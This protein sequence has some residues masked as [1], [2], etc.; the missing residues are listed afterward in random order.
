M[1]A[2]S[3]NHLMGEA[4]WTFHSPATRSHTQAT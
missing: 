3:S 4:V 2:L 1:W